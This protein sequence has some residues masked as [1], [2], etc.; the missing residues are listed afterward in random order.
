MRLCSVGRTRWGPLSFVS[1]LFGKG[2]RPP[3]DLPPHPLSKPL[4]AVTA[5]AV[6]PLALRSWI[7]GRRREAIGIAART[8]ERPP[9]PRRTNPVG[10]PRRERGPAALLRFPTLALWYDCQRPMRRSPLVAAVVTALG[11]LISAPAAA[12]PPSSTLEAVSVLLALAPA[13][14]TGELR[15]VIDRISVAVPKKLYKPMKLSRIVLEVTVISGTEVARLAHTF[16]S[17]LAETDLISRRGPNRR[18]LVSVDVGPTLLFF[19][20]S[21]GKFLELCVQAFE[22]KRRREK[23]IGEGSCRLPPVLVRVRP[24]QHIYVPFG[25]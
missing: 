18:V 9:S 20:P 17:A 14:D 13:P 24:N 8:P 4:K 2:V 21:R 6:D 23:A 1:V 3:P 12:G 10:G 19:T 7:V 25:R 5:A 11:V 22:I 16:R 15:S